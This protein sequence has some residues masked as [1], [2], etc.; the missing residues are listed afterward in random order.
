MSALLTPAAPASSTGGARPVRWTVPVFHRAREAGQLE[1]QR[2]F[3]LRGVLMEQGPMNPPHA[4]CIEY[5]T[6]ILNKVFADGWRIR[7]QLPLVLNLDTD[8]FP[9]FAVI[10]G[11]LRDAKVKHPTTASL[12][13]EVSDTTFDIDTGEKAE[14]YA[15]AGIVDYWVLDVSDRRLIVYREPASGKEAYRSVMTLKETD[16][17]SPLAIPGAVISVKDL[18]P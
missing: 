9:D 10:Q 11:S 12:V 18:L 4:M 7:C 14:L 17:V 3:L 8:P 2:T 1:G 5:V 13:I 15:A 16:S 6:A